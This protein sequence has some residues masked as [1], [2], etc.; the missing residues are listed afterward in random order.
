MND[1]RDRKWITGFEALDLLDVPSR[2]LA[3]PL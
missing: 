2:A 1:V 3:A